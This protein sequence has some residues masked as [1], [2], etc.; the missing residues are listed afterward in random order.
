MDPD[1][2]SQHPQVRPRS[3]RGRASLLKKWIYGVSRSSVVGWKF[4]RYDNERK[5][6]AN[7][8]EAIRLILKIRCHIQRPSGNSTHRNGN[9]TQAGDHPE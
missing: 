3:A 4:A 6:L 2:R 7:Q 5:D 1:S 8:G 9:N